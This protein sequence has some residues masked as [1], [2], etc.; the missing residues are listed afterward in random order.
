MELIKVNSQI[1][2]IENLKNTKFE[3]WTHQKKMITR[4]NQIEQNLKNTN[5]PIGIMG[6]KPGTGKTYVA[7]GLILNDLKFSENECNLIVVPQ[8]IFSQWDEA[9]K[10]FCDLSKVR[11]KSFTTYSDITNIYRDNTIFKN[12]DIILTTSLYYHLV[13]GTINGMKEINLNRVFFDEIDTINNMIREKINSK[14]IW[15]IS[16]SFKENKIGCYTLNN[17]PQRLCI[18]EEK[19]INDSLN[20]KEPINNIISCYNLF[21]EMVKDILPPKTISEL[22]AMDFN[23]NTYKFITKVPKNEKEYLEYLLEDLKE[24]MINNQNNIQNILKAKKEMEDSGFFSGLILQQKINS[25]INQVKTSESF[26]EGAKIL[27]KQLYERLRDRQICPLTFTNLENGS[28]LVSK[29]CKMCYYKE[30]ISKLTT[31]ILC[32][33]CDKELKYPNSYLEERKLINRPPKEDRTYKI[34]LLK[35][36]LIEINKKSEQK[37]II[38]SDYPAIFKILE[39]YFK[40]NKIDFIT[41]DGGSIESLNNAVEKYKKGSISFLLVDSSM[42]GCGMNFENTENII[43]IHKTNPELEKQVIGR[44]QRPGRKS[45]L[46]IYRLLHINENS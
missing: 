3:L 29:C 21:T 35:N 41:L 13:S 16:A 38:F 25:F 30:Y 33:L 39:D 12:V 9:I 36:L 26:I 34:D 31:G 8:N 22:N 23:T 42:N 40:D 2:S 15:F 28:K 43:F 27:K 6:D 37:T 10:N 44:A 18:C 1:P 17:L 20:L 14:F 11:Y 19:L 4:C 24:I 32:N 7:L 45:I 46:N 5:E